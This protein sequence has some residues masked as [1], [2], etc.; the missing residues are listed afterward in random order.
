MLTIHFVRDSGRSCC[1]TRVLTI[2]CGGIPSFFFF[3][4]ECPFFL[5]DQT[6]T[7][8][9]NLKIRLFRAQF[10]EYDSHNKWT[11]PRIRLI[12][13]FCFVGI[14]T[15]KNFQTS[16]CAR[17]QKKFFSS[18]SIYQSNRFPSCNATF[19]L[20]SSFCK[21]LKVINICCMRPEAGYWHLRPHLWPVENMD[22]IALY[23]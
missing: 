4:M 12:S 9:K 10:W 11:R 18:L 20:L 14:H 13:C 22:I 15:Y 16:F 6:N 19:F 8:K 23:A 3:E 21:S 7:P 1:C 5:L 17:A 2:K